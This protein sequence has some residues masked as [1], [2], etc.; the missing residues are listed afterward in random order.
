MPLTE[1]SSRKTVSENI[2]EMVKSGHPQDQAVAAALENARADDIIAPIVQEPNAEI[3]PTVETA[4]DDLSIAEKMATGEIDLPAELHKLAP[5][6]RD[7]RHTSKAQAAD[8]LAKAVSAL[9][10][11]A[12][13][14]VAVE[15]LGLDETLVERLRAE[16]PAP[17]ETPLDRITSALG[18]Q[19]G[20]TE[21]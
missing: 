1:G 7:A 6:W 5:V 13:T 11:I 14:D 12:D 15:M 20:P 10:W 8:W 16:R 21:G 19:A 17:S 2:S 18:R 9:P 3:V 4:T